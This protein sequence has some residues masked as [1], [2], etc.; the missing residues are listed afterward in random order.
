MEHLVN[1]KEHVLILAYF[2]LG[3]WVLRYH[4]LLASPSKPQADALVLPVTAVPI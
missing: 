1:R 3:R 2:K 4:W